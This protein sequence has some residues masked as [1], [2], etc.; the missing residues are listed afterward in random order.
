[1]SNGTLETWNTSGLANGVYVLRLFS[2]ST[3]GQF[4]PACYVRV[5]IAR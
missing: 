5:V 2:V 3:N 1:V 4:P